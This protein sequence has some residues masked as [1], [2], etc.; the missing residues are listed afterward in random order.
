MKK[1][2]LQNFK[3]KKSA[4]VGFIKITVIVFTSD[5]LYAITL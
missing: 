3:V 1:A 5:V 4:K 2:P